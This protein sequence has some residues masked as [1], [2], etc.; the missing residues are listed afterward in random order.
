MARLPT[1]R[2]ESAHQAVKRAEVIQPFN[3]HLHLATTDAEWA[4]LNKTFD[5]T[6]MTDIAESMGGAQFILDS[7]ANNTPHC[8]IWLNPKMTGRDKADTIAHEAFHA[9]AQLFDHIEQATTK[10]DSEYLA[11]MVGWIAGWLT[12]QTA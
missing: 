11:Y 1:R 6:L 10:H 8:V 2:V 12:E 4:A 7:E 9:A 3:Y 5:G